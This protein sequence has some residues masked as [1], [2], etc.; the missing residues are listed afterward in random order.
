[1]DLVRHYYAHQNMTAPAY[2][3]EYIYH[4]TQGPN[5]MRHF[6]VSTAAFRCLE[7]APHPDLAV[8]NPMLHKTFYAPGSNVSDSIKAVLAKNPET[9]ID[10]IEELVRLKRTEHDPRHGPDCDWHV[11]ATA[12]CKAER[13]EPWQ[14]D[15]AATSIPV[16]PGAEGVPVQRQYEMAKLAQIQ[17]K[18]RELQLQE[19]AQKVLIARHRP[20]CKPSW[21]NG[22]C[23][24]NVKQTESQIDGP[25]DE[26]RRTGILCSFSDIL[27]AVEPPKP[28]ASKRADP[29][30][31]GD[32]P[33]HAN[34]VRGQLCS[35]S[36]ILTPVEPP[37][38]AESDDGPFKRFGGKMRGHFDKLHKKDAPAASKLEA[39]KPEAPK[40]AAPKLEPPKPDKPAEKPEAP[41]SDKPADKPAA[42][43]APTK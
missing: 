33:K 42:P 27:T 12:K 31:S 11:H 24:C 25:A 13:R 20:D 34:E 1:M 36:N 23:R 30:K 37:K 21:F 38:P 26:V 28:A 15:G 16:V 35:F 9:A 18:I 40:P 17:Q 6:L 22:M 19:A 41:K 10:F 14:T 43:P 7:E 39:P 29:A 2:R 8:A 32:P 3:L 4:Y 5:H